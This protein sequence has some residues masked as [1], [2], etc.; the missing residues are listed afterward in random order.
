MW[1]RSRRIPPVLYVDTES[2]A[3]RF[4]YWAG[5]LIFVLLG[6]GLMLWGVLALRGSGRGVVRLVIGSLVAGVFGFAYTV[7]VVS[8]VV[9]DPAPAAGK[10]S[11]GPSATPA[12][13]PSPTPTPVRKFK[14][15]PIPD[16]GPATRYAS[17]SRAF[18]VAN[19]MR[20]EV[21]RQ[22]KRGNVNAAVTALIGEMRLVV[23]NARCFEDDFV[24]D[25]RTIKLYDINRQLPP[26]LQRIPA[27]CQQ[28]A[29]DAY[30][31]FGLVT[32]A[33]HE[34]EGDLDLG[35]GIDVLHRNH[36]ECVT[37]EDVSKLKAELAKELP[38]AS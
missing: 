28:V 8:A 33:A 30:R 10:P 11:P 14:P 18:E 37:T 3:Y 32:S 38:S 29:T 31:L 23:A 1:V 21:I 7:Q 25:A 4:G 22:A 12:P 13:T 2:N 35:A 34:T 20:S 16:P 9:D 5:P 36:P 6:V 27:A 24:K 19:A 15:R 17:C 26:N